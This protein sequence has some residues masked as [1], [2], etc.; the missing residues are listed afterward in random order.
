RNDNRRVPRAAV[1][2]PDGLPDDVAGPAI[3]GD[4]RRL[5]AAGRAN[6]QFAVDE[7]RFAVTPAISLLTVEVLGKILPPDFLA[8][9]RPAT[10]Q[11]PLRRNGIHEFAL[12]RRSAA[13][14]LPVGV[15]LGPCRAEASFPDRLAVAL[16]EADEIFVFVVGDRRAVAEAVN[17]SVADR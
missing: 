16:L 9:G 3:Q 1:A 7:G 12:H 15:S 8:V 11:H 6:D 14:A 13:G 5:L 17:P 2:G 4:H 10:D